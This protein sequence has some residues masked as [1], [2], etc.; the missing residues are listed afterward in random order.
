MHYAK[1]FPTNQLP[2]EAVGIAGNVSFEK[3]CLTQAPASASE[4]IIDRLRGLRSNFVDLRMGVDRIADRIVGVSPTPPGCGA[5][6]GNVRVEPSCFL[7][8]LQEVIS[9]LEQVARETRE[10]LDRLQRSF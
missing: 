7:D 4:S 9:D 8:S 6:T 1:D 5:S 2:R 3:A 10:Q